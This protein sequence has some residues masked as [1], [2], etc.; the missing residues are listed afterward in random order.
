M[1]KGE[2]KSNE[3]RIHLKIRG[4]RGLEREI[5]AIV[6]TGYSGSLTWPPALI[7]TLG[8]KRRSIGYAILAD[9]STTV[10]DVHTALVTWDGAQR[11]I[12]VDGADANPLVE[13]KLLRGHELK[14]QVVS[15]G[16][17]TITRVQRRRK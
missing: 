6:D 1:I 14:I 3:A 5:R 4:K 13:M 2:V 9:G 7:A 12:L 17:V 10:F 15:G 8:L 16:E 11:K